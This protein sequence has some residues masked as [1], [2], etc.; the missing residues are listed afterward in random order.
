MAIKNRGVMTKMG[1]YNIKNK[2][3]VRPVHYMYLR[4]AYWATV[5]T[6]QSDIAFSFI[7][8]NTRQLPFYNLC[9]SRPPSLRC[10][11]TKSRYGQKSRIY[12]GFSSSATQATVLPGR[13]IKNRGT[14][15]PMLFLDECGCNAGFLLFSLVLWKI[16]RALHTVHNQTTETNFTKAR[17]IVVAVVR[18]VLLIFY[19]WIA[20]F[21]VRITSIVFKA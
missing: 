15:L 18:F 16:T 13:K 4:C 9:Y 11:R 2:D 20:Q 3:G 21:T 12:R 6:T 17:V 7:W 14:V 10:W 8:K 1:I 5:G 19:I